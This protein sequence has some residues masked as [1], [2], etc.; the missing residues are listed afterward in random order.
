MMNSKFQNV[1]EVNLSKNEDII[2]NRIK[3]V[4]ICWLKL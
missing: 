3:I 4:S 2:V 1:Y